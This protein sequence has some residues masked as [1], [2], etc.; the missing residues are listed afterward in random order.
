M[1]QLLNSPT[2]WH[3]R[4]TEARGVAD[5]MDDPEAKRAMLEIARN[6]ENL[7]ERAERRLVAPQEKTS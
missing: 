7:A 4:A 6:Y 2:H 5:K 3:G 1:S